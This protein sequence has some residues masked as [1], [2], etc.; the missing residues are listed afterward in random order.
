MAHRRAVWCDRVRVRHYRTFEDDR[1]KLSLIVSVVIIIVLREL[2]ALYTFGTRRDESVSVS[3]RLDN[4][5]RKWFHWG[6]QNIDTVTVGWRKS[7]DQQERINGNGVQEFYTVV[8]KGK[9]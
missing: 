2:V 8:R 1:M 6:E 3:E 4:L 9:K 7:E 5:N